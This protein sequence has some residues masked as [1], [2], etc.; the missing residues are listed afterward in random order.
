MTCFG[1]VWF[2]TAVLLAEDKELGSRNQP[3]K[4]H[5][6]SGTAQN[7]L[8]NKRPLE[9]KLKRPTGSVPPTLC[10]TTVS[11]CVLSGTLINI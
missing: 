2:G 8:A 3:K 1:G 4:Q 5:K 7:H 6:N 11:F 9:E 10:Y